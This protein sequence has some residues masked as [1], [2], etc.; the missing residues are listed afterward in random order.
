MSYLT[1]LV[2]T[3]NAG[4]FSDALTLTAGETIIT[5]DVVSNGAHTKSRM[6][7]QHSPDG[8]N[9]LTSHQS[10]NGN[11]SIT[12]TRATAYVRAYVVVAEGT[13]Q[14]ATILITSK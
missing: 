14:T 4:A 9:W 2:S 7:L 10:T 8:I 1:E 5:L 3:E 12:I 6:T 13:A 11:G